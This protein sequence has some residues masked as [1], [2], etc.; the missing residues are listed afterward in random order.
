MIVERVAIFQEIVHSNSILNL[1]LIQS[2]INNNTC[3]NIY[4]KYCNI[5]LGRKGQDFHE[6]P[7]D[8]KLLFLDYHIYNVTNININLNP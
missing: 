1:L 4:N 5:N 3:N 2:F 8:F 7:H 6:K